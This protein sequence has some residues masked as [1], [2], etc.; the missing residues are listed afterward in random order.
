[1]DTPREPVTERVTLFRCGFKLP[2]LAVAKLQL[3]VDAMDGYERVEPGVFLH[4][5]F[6]VSGP[7]L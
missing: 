5:V 1:M 6:T 3:H 2:I 7:P 4:L